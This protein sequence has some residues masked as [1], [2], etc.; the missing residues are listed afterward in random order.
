VNDIVVPLA[1]NIEVQ[2]ESYLFNGH[3]PSITIASG[4][5]VLVGPNGAGKTQVLRGLKSALPNHLSNCTASKVRY[6]SAGRASPLERFR[7]RSENPHNSDDNPTY[8]GNA[9]YSSHWYNYESLTG[10]YLVLEQRADLRLKVQARLQAFLSRSIQ[11][12]WG[13]SGLEIRIVPNSGGATYLANNEASG[14]L[15][16]APLLAAIYNEEVG[17]LLIDEPEISLHPQYQAFIMQELQAVAGNPLTEP[18]KKLVIIATHSPNIL[19][20]RS[21]SDLPSMVFFND[22]NSPP[23]QIAIGSGEL[24]N[25]KLKA[26]IARL[27]ATHR[28]AFFARNVLLVEG[29]SDE[30]I[31][32]QLA[33]ALQHPLLAAN[34][35]IVPVIGKSEFVDAIKLFEMMGK[36]VFV[37][38]DLDAL[39]DSNVLVN[40]FSTRPEA[41]DAALAVGHNTLIELDYAI[42]SKFS[43]IVQSHWSAIQ[44]RVSTHPYWEQ[45]REGEHTDQVR[46]RATLAFLMSNGGEDLDALTGSS[47]FVAIKKR[48]AVL[49]ETLEAAGCFILQKGTVEDYYRST[50]NNISKIDAAA[51]EAEAFEDAPFGKFQTN[52]SD[53]IRAIEA[54]APIQPVDENLFLRERL[55]GMLGAIFQ[56][57][58]TGTPSSELNSRARN[59]QPDASIFNLDNCSS[60]DELRIRVSINSPLFQRNTFPFEVSINENLTKIIRDKLPAL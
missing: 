53:I 38:A 22:Q 20:L 1:I 9:S 36:R 59:F 57:M 39:T 37:L 7:A 45:C 48:F 16:L 31:T 13:Q 60:L 40:K 15:Q 3:K 43:G 19:A 51:L 25:V 14:V 56:F 26:L 58:E 11:L 18:G 35:Q 34:T 24:N 50:N 4:L 30:I 28:L 12:T 47:D 8:V 44:S 32:S 17:A 52:Y 23:I 5:T 33:R 55:G 46:R 41:K 27:T 21:V 29:P 49:F 10:D 2:T 6:L 54:A 42:R